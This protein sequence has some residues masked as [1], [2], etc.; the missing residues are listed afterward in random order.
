MPLASTHKELLGH[1]LRSISKNTD[2]KSEKRFSV[3][4]QVS[5][6]CRWCNPRKTLI[7]NKDKLTETLNKNS[8]YKLIKTTNK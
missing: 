3:V 5:E 4:F 1:L 2:R 8:E 7:L 6:C